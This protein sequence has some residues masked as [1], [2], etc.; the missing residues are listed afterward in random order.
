MW[1][2][3]FRD[4]R[5]YFLSIKLLSGLD[6]LAYLGLT[7]ERDEEKESRGKATRLS[8]VSTRPR[9]EESGKNVWRG[10]WM[11]AYNG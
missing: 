2:S 4:L 7:R 11:D 3:E 5:S 1:I 8:T 10:G 9:A 6:S